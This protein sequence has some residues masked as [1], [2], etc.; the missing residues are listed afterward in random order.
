MLAALGYIAIVAGLGTV[1]LCVDSLVG[2]E[3]VSAT[4]DSEIRFYAVWYV[5]AGALLL[6]SA[7]N[8]ERAG[9]LI[10]GLAGLLFVAGVSR[11][12]SWL[13]S[14]NHIVFTD[15]DGH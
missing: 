6:W 15:I 9:A 10:R 5:G 1:F 3:D 11:G 12:L 13:V 8:V 14:A 2:A 4:V 7:A